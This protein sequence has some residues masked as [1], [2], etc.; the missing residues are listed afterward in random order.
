MVTHPPVI[1][2]QVFP[3]S[4]SLDE[5]VKGFDFDIAAS[6]AA[7][8]DRGGLVHV[9]DSGFIFEVAGDERTHWA[10]IDR[11]SGQ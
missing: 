11:V 8:T 6:G 2:V 3:W 9:P 5:A 4:Q 10:D 7:S 1:D